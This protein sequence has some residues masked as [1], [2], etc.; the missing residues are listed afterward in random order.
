[1]HTKKHTNNLRNCT[2]C[3][4]TVP[5]FSSY[6]LEN[7]RWRHFVPLFTS[8][9]SVWPG[10]SKP[11]LP[12]LRQS[13]HGA[14][15]SADS[16]SFEIRVENRA[17]SVRITTLSSSSTGAECGEIARKEERQEDHPIPSMSDARLW[18]LAMHSCLL[19]LR[20][21]GYGTLKHD[22]AHGDGCS[23]CCCPSSGRDSEEASTLRM[24]AWAWDTRS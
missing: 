7:C 9:P 19:C 3:G 8:P 6:L 15:D 11:H 2:T 16:R 18:S 23:S 21:L 13:E 5:L 1:M 12:A 20:G 24:G 10:E 4:N 17:W 14:D 22:A